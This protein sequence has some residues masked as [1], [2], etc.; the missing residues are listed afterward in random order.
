VDKALGQKP[1]L[2]QYHDEL[3]M[4]KNREKIRTLLEGGNFYYNKNDALLLE[5]VLGQ[6]YENCTTCL[7]MML[8]FVAF[9]KFEICFGTEEENE[10]D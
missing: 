4:N 10:N 5:N 6:N 8:V 1:G 2:T 9:Y 7:G 3:C